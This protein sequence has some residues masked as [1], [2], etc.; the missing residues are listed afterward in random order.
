MF[1]RNGVKNRANQNPPEHAIYN[2]FWRFWLETWI[3]C[4][5]PLRVNCQESKERNY[6][7]NNGSNKAEKRT[8]NQWKNNN[9]NKKPTTSAV[10]KETHSQLVYGAYGSKV[11][12]RY[13]HFRLMMIWW[14]Q[15]ESSRRAAE[16]KEEQ[17]EGVVKGSH[18]TGRKKR[19][20]KI[21]L[22]SERA[23]GRKER[24]SERGEQE[25]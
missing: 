8:R 13:A 12:S 17:W 10:A 2:D 15:I 14:S 1:N 23:I 18:Q 7:D 24:R 3:Q 19:E 6:T 16:T 9:N 11:H 4:V 25:I 5:M 22:L 21:V 20:E